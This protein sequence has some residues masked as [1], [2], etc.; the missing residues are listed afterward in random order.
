MEGENIKHGFS[1]SHTT[2]MPRGQ[3]ERRLQT[4]IQM[5][6][7][8]LQDALSPHDNNNN[9]NTASSSSTCAKPTQSLCYAS[10]ADNIARLLKEWKKNPPKKNPSRT[11]SNVTQNSLG[12]LGACGG[13]ESVQNKENCS[14]ETCE[15]TF[16]SLFG[17]ESL[18]SSNSEFSQSLSPDPEIT[19]TTNIFQDEIKP[20]SNADLPLSFIEKWLLDEVSFPL[21]C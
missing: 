19:T 3:W 18:D 15:T 16:E 8:A 5:A 9:N 7:R 13:K 10:T 4:D 11:N 6:K 12:N 17:L 21:L 2:I 20:E 1:A 14:F